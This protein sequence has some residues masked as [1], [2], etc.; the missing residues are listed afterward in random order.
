MKLPVAITFLAALVL[1]TIAQDSPTARGKSP[2]KNKPTSQTT[3]QN[4]AMTGKPRQEI[5]VTAPQPAKESEVNTNALPKM[6]KQPAVSYGGLAS[7]I[8]KSTNRW[9]MF[10]IRRPANPKEDDANMVRNLRTEGG[11]GVKVFSVDF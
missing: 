3:S 5:E 11:P 6:P 8:R 9:K 10:S 4:A 7:D 2:T 1:A